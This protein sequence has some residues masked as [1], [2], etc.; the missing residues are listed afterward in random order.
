MA[1]SNAKLQESVKSVIDKVESAEWRKFKDLQAS[2]FKDDKGRIQKLKRSLIKNGF[3]APFYAWRSGSQIF[4]CDGHYRRRALTE[5]SKEGV[6]VPKSLPTVFI[7][8]SSKDHA[9]K[10]LLIFNS[11]YAD[12]Q[13]PGLTNFA[14]G[15][16][17]ESMFGEIELPRMKDFSK[18]FQPGTDEPEP[19]RKKPAPDENPHDDGPAFHKMGFSLTAKQKK[20]VNK[21]V[22]S[23]RSDDGREDDEA[24]R[25]AN[26]NALVHICSVYLRARSV[27]P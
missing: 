1:R 8:A 7:K 3:A 9:K 21:A 10:L 5:L 14:K 22:K 6:D 2:D 16:D 26:S 20:I 24:N 13:L 19:T 15:L 17:V 18:L 11:H 23:A 12:I 4:T 27:D 25:S